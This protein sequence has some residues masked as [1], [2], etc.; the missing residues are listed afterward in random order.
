MRALQVGFAMS[1][2]EPLLNLRINSQARFE[3]FHLITML[4]GIVYEM[5]VLTASFQVGPFTCSSNCK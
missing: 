3:Y 1:G 5:Q 2:K 4:E